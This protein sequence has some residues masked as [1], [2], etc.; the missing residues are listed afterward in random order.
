VEWEEV[1]KI[2]L[3]RA[4]ALVGSIG[5][6]GAGVAMLLDDYLDI[7]KSG[8]ERNPPM[9][10]HWLY[11]VIA[12]IA[13]VTGVGLTILDIDLELRKIKATDSKSKKLPNPLEGVP[14]KVLA[15]LK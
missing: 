1:S 8:G 7:G 4:P 13:G 11:G 2:I 9:P 10:H 15:S 14:E 5:A 6:L 3:A 12:L